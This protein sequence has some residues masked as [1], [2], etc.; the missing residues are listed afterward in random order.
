M[1]LADT[2]GEGAGAAADGAAGVVGVVGVAEVAEVVAGCAWS[3]SPPR[4]AISESRR[5]ERNQRF[6]RLIVLAIS[7]VRMTKTGGVPKPLSMPCRALRFNT[8]AN[9]GTCDP[10]ATPQSPSPPIALA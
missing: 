4:V 1:A 6:M 7:G 2:E 9:P 5:T 8:S 10:G 3:A